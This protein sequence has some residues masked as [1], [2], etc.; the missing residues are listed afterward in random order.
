MSVF[1]SSTITVRR[2]A[3]GALGLTFDV[4]GRSVNVIT[5][6]LLADLDC[7]LDAL[8]TQSR[9]PVL[10]VQSGKKT[11]FLAGADLKE[12]LAIRDAASATAMSLRGQKVFQRL[13]EL[14]FPT[15]AA[16]HGPCLGGGLELALACDYR[17][18]VDRPGT[19]FGLP[20][21]TLGLLPAW[22]GTQ[23]LPRTMGLQRALEIILTG[24]RLDAKQAKQWNLVDAVSANDEGQLR[25]AIVKLIGRAMTH[26]KRSR[27]G[28]P[29]H[30]WRQW[31]L[32]ST[33]VGRRII[34]SATERLLRRRVPD[35]MP[36]PYEAVE[37]VRVGLR[38]GMTAGLTQEREAASRLALTPA[39]RNLVTLFFQREQARKPEG[40]VTVRRV[41]LI[42]AGVMGAGIAQLAALRGLDVVVKEVNA[43]ALSA[44]MARI[45]ELFD[46][47]VE[48]KIVSA[49]EAQRR[50]AAIRGTAEWD[51]FEGVDVVI[52]AAVE[53]LEIKRRLF[54]E[55]LE[56]TSSTT[57]LATNTSSLRIAKIAE[58]LSPPERIGGLHFFN[59][60]HKMPL[61][62]VVR[63]PATSE[64]SIATLSALAALLG[65]TPVTVG[66]GPGFVVNRI[67]MPYLNEAVVSLQ[68]CLRIKDIDA[69]MRRFG[70][71]MGPLELLDQIGLDV[72]AHV[73]QSI[74]PELGDRF[75]PNDAFD[76]MVKKGW[77]GEKNGTGFYN[78]HGK[79]A[80]VN[81][82]A[83]VVVLGVHRIRRKPGDDRLRLAEARERMVLSM[84]N[85][86]ARVL[87]E[88]L[89]DS[90]ASID[91]AMV[92]GTGWAP[93]RGGPLRYA[94][95]RG[96]SEVVAALNGLAD[97]VGPRFRPCEELIR[98][99]ESGGFFPSDA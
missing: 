5:P 68:E 48:R 51:G 13:A 16:I 26:R 76:R 83:E 81:D 14:R 2:D 97:R 21:V 69:I 8:Q 62:E 18:A 25:S 73:A 35:D 32:E 31:F 57:I 36:A 38:S 19:Q 85:E 86:A 80:T 24:K 89:A 70:M 23:R 50:R 17:L 34:F 1:E 54:A 75:V 33:G 63:G 10:L 3:D 49:E 84:V 90:A 15:I 27:T 99:A 93:H 94:T 41:G 59:P 96:V 65:K 12:F 74:G 92:L 67:L 58:G 78:H 88:G 46:R 45:Q 6:E 37:A 7:A 20:E 42:G 9:V 77:L 91:L 53:N 98:R 71:P 55:L 30:G 87:A 66:D 52:E 64:K 44:G 56:K 28:L 82:E 40:G 95:D 72:A 29:L 4:P 60:V 39:C 47:A 79:K 43:E 61:V 11:G 22:G